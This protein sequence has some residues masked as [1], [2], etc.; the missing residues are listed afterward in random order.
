SSGEEEKDTCQKRAQNPAQMEG[1]EVDGQM[2][3]SKAPP[4]PTPEEKM[5]QQAQAVL[6]DIV[7]INVT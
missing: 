2:S 6:T 7:P 5:R 4:L 3:R 1:V